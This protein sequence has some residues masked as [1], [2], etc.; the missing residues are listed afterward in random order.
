MFT[1]VFEHLWWTLNIV[2]IVSDFIEWFELLFILVGCIL[3]NIVVPPTQGGLG[4]AG[5]G[6][7]GLVAGH[8]ENKNSV[9]IN[10]SRLDTAGLVLVQAG[11]AWA[12][13]N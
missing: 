4:W 1:S 8:S 5:L 2:C 13:I 12:E 10:L 9:P 11:A 3:H 7:A 6:W